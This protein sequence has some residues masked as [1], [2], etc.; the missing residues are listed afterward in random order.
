MV[1]TSIISLRDLSK[2]F[3][4]Y[5]HP[6]GRVLQML[7]ISGRMFYKEFRAL[8]NITLDIMKGESVGIIG[9]NGCG[10]STLLQ[11][12]CGTLTPT[13]GSIE[14]RGKISALLELG[15]G[16]HPDF[17]GRENVM[18]HG[19]IMGF[20]SREMEGRFD[21]IAAF[22][23]IGDFMDEPVRSYSSGMFVRLAFATATHVDADVLIVDEALSVG[24]AEFS[25]KSLRFMQSFREKGTVIVVSHDIDTLK[26]LCDR[27]LLLSKGELIAD[28]QPS[29]VCEQYLRIAYNTD[30][31]FS[32]R[33]FEPV[34]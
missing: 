20:S 9:H 34:K 1:D 30:E 21:Q 29:A 15:A 8:K 11:L 23:D 26:S 28:G 14:V 10:K 19:A 16:F 27:V 22:A 32:S 2:T 12:I 7:S 25:A 18:M 4:I 24:D 31:G 5:S 33:H 3:R 17:T 6:I 13:S